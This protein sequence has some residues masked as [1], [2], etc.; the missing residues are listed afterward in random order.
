MEKIGY[1]TVERASFISNWDAYGHF[2]F[3]LKEKNKLL[4]FGFHFE[5]EKPKLNNKI[6]S[7]AHM[8]KEKNSESGIESGKL[9][10]LLNM[11]K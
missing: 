11:K 4:L 9:T 6:I 5:E 7:I 3:Y 10:S 1:S 8:F 2:R